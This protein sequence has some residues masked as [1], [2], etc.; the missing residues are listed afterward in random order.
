MI[1]G[2]SHSH[3][4]MTELF[5][6]TFLSQLREDQRQSRLAILSWAVVILIECPDRTVTIAR[7]SLLLYPREEILHGKHILIEEFADD[8]M[9]LHVP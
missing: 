5:L 8:D 3:A 1:Q 6:I 9:H 4:L 2:G 7:N